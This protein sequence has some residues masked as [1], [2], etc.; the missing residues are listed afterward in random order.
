[1][2]KTIINE[3]SSK[4]EKIMKQICL[5]LDAQYRELDD[6]VTGLDENQWHCK[7]PYFNWSIFD[8]IAH[9]TFFDH[10]ALLAIED[11]D[12]FRE[13]AK[14][15]ISVIMTDGSF[16]SYTNPLLGL[17]NPEELLSSWRDIR[18]QLIQHLDMMDPKDRLP[19]YG[20]DMSARSFATARLMETW[21]HSQ[22]VFDTLRIKRVNTGRIRHVAH[23]GVTTFGWSFIL[24][25]LKAPEIKPRI[26]LT[27]PGG[28]L[29]EWGEAGESEWVSGSA[30]EFCLVVTQRR[31]VADTGLT[32]QGE[33]V[34]KWLTIAQAFAGVPQDHPAPGV[35]LVEY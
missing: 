17:E 1:M 18:S 7:T 15:M 23:I 21:A 27:A 25:G 9:I 4:K 3:Q 6:L 8:Q 32:W 19:W 20:P 33:N 14:K 12:R 29:W 2:P 35:R 22:D 16:P 26:E 28:D 13:H 10:T 34:S 11:L 5:D 24:K 30:E 31:N